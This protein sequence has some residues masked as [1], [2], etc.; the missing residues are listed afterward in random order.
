MAERSD[1]RRGKAVNNRV[2]SRPLQRLAPGARI[3]CWPGAARLHTRGRI[4]DCSP[5]PLLRVAG[6]LSSDDDPGREGGVHIG[7]VSSGLKGQL[8]SDYDRACAVDNLIGVVP[9][10]DGF[11]LILAGEP[12]PTTWISDV[13]GAAGALVRWEYADADDDVRIAIDLLEDPPNV[14][15]QVAFEVI[16][17]LVLFDSAYPGTQSS[18]HLAIESLVPGR[19]SIAT[20]R[21]QPTP[22][23]SFYVHRF[24]RSLL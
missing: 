16:G 7:V 22:R 9:V 6:M 12:L 18:A 4:Y 21:V 8:G 13:P 24:I 15:G 19:Y 10:G 1:R 5:S 17:S 20:E 23:A 14:E 2:P 3:P 11:G